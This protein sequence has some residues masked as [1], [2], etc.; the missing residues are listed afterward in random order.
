MFPDTKL[1]FISYCGER[2]FSSKYRSQMLSNQDP[3]IPRCRTTKGDHDDTSSLRIA[4]S[5][6]MF[7]N[8]AHEGLVFLRKLQDGLVRLNAESD[9]IKLD[10]DTKA[11]ATMIYCNDVL[12]NFN[13]M[14]L[15]IL[16]DTAILSAYGLNSSIPYDQ[17]WASA[18][19]CQVRRDTKTLQ[20]SIL[21]LFCSLFKNHFFL[22]GFLL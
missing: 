1:T 5:R 22:L 21:F 13:A 18:S 19:S 6:K 20:T 10:I 14:M 16:Q 15:N 11:I 9:P 3:V 4:G 17:V 2:F 12:V 8:M 7:A